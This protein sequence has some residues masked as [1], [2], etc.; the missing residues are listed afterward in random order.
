MGLVRLWA[1]HGEVE[2][3]DED[4]DADLE[5]IPQNMESKRSMGDSSSAGSRLGS[6]CCRAGFRA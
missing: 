4:E 6:T 1:L 3:E 5:Y 2:D